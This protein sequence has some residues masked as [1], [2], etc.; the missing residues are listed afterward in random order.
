MSGKDNYYIEKKR[1][2]TMVWVK[3]EESHL[4]E[5]EKNSSCPELLFIG[6]ILL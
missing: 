1:R 5:E 4:D 3:D 6:K 2:I